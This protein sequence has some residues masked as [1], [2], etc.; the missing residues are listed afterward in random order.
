MKGKSGFVFPVISYL[1]TNFQD[2]KHMILMFQI[3][4]RIQKQDEQEI[5]IK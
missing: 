4:N 2:Y 3:N 5:T 1:Q